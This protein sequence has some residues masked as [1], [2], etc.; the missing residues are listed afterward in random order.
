MTILDTITHTRGKIQFQLS[1]AL[2]REY[3]IGKEE[4]KVLRHVQRLGHIRMNKLDLN[5]GIFVY[6][7]NRE[8]EA[9][10][11]HLH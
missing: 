4:R 1:K 3:N 9:I 2:K 11:G 8:H 10:T 7:L 6:F 5:V